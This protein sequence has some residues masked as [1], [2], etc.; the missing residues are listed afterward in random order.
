MEGS[1]KG[2]LDLLDYFLLI[3]EHKKKKK[4]FLNIYIFCVFFY[5]VILAATAWFVFCENDIL[6]IL[7]C[8]VFYRVEYLF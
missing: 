2:L 5:I 1:R 6:F 7:Y 8:F 3:Y 4:K